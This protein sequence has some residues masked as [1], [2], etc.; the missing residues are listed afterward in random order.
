LPYANGLS[1]I[2]GHHVIISGLWKDSRRG[3]L[4]Q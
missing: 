2:S 4:G 3:E 1:L